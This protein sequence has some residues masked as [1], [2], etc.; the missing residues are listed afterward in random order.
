MADPF[1]AECFDVIVMWNVCRFNIGSLGRLETVTTQKLNIS[2]M[3][4]EH[5]PLSSLLSSF[6]VPPPPMMSCHLHLNLGMDSPY[7][8]SVEWNLA[9]VL[10]MTELNKGESTFDDE[11]SS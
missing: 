3:S 11:Y 2:W 4:V 5:I 10:H 7:H 9:S 6:Y 1:C 8:V